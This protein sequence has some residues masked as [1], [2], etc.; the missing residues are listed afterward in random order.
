MGKYFPN[1]NRNKIKEEAEK[2]MKRDHIPSE[3]IAS[4]IFNE[5]MRPSNS[6][7]YYPDHVTDW[8]QMNKIG[9]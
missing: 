3:R 9:M 1:K 2:R 7:E 6:K 8:V 4:R 5:S